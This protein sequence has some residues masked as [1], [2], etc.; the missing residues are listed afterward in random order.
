MNI[1]K[2]LELKRTLKEFEREDREIKASQKQV[3]F[4]EWLSTI[5]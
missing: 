5:K 3:S 1:N 2:K 4:S